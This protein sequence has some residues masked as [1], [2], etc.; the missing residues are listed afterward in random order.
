MAVKRNQATVIRKDEVPVF[1]RKTWDLINS[2]NETCPDTACWSDD[3]RSFLVKDQEK[4]ASSIIPQ[5]FR[6]NNF[7]SFVRQLNF[8]GFKKQKSD[9]AHDANG[10]SSFRHDDFRMGRED[11]LGTIRKANQID[12]VDREEVE[13]L[14]EEV[15]YL[16]KEMGRMA[17]VLEH[18]SQH[19]IG[20]QGMH[21]P[22]VPHEP[23]KKRM[24]IEPDCV[25][26]SVPP[27]PNLAES[28][29]DFRRENDYEP[30]VI[31]HDH[32]GAG[33]YPIT[34]ASIFGDGVLWPEWDCGI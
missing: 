11:L 9:A 33:P 18:M 5:Y 20:G 7:S 24:K 3:G 2:C 16:R 30:N 14:R 15:G 4:F 12:A 21:V 27:L 25:G 34:D 32:A 6:H 1:L 10:W 28:N 8:Y 23:P 19:I 31:D 26:S 13:K 29:S 17:A 22:H